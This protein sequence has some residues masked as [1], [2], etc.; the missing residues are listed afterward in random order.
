M[1]IL[2]VAP[3]AGVSLSTG[4][5]TNLLL[6]QAKAFAELGH[7]VEIAGFHAFPL[8]RLEAIHGLGLGPNR[9]RVRVRSGG[10]R[11]GY[12]VHRGLPG[13]PSP[14]F[15]LLDPRVR[16]WLAGLGDA[17][18]PDLA[19]FHD[20][21]PIA[22]AGWAARVRCRLYVH[23]PLLGR[24][25]RVAPALRE[26]RSAGEAAQDALLRRGAGRLVHPRPQEIAEAVE[27]NS[28]VTERACRTVWGARASVWPTYVA[29][30]PVAEGAR[31]RTVVSLG[32]IHRGKGHALLLEA[33][34]RA[35]V[36]GS[37][38]TILGHA[39]DPALLTE[40]RRAARGAPPA[41]VALRTDAPR[42]EVEATLGSARAIV[43]GAAFEPFGL[44]V[45]EGMGAGA[46]PIVRESPDSGA[47]TD[48]VD[49]GR[50]GTGFA[51]LEELAER[52]RERLGP[53][54]APPDGAARARAASY[55]EARFVAT[56]REAIA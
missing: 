33:F 42:G 3:N 49:E 45:L 17:V 50:F 25:L 55:S 51:S 4:G 46:S 1:K 52:L 5:G 38:L 40:L 10:G 12:A 21:L 32:S 44:A 56:A 54:Q 31:E 20:D 8:D 34:R 48:L 24:S 35:E 19:Y 41:S 29:L 43:G 36:A 9:S 26:S 27:A 37:R 15:A 18:R 39:R 23:Y 28:R 13:K 2:L 14:Y 7:D 30:R 16:A 47:W 22:A 11:A 53:E 6:K